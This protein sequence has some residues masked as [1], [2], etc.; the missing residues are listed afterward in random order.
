MKQIAHDLWV[1]RRRRCVE[2]VTDTRFE[3]AFRN[4]ESDALPLRQSVDGSRYI[5]IS[6]SHGRATFLQQHC[7]V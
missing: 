6:E 1:Y 5:G 7:G 2:S 3:R 4:L